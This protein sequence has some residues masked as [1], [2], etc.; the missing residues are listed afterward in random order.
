M[1][2]QHYFKEKNIF[3]HYVSLHMKVCKNEK[4]HKL[5]SVFCNN[6]EI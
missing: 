2:A 1:L 4:K 6:S 3:F 5:Q